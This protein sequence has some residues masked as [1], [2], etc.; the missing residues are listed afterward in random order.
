MARHHSIDYLE[1]PAKDLAAAKGFF[2]EL[3]GW[4]FSDF[5]PDYSAFKNAGVEGGFYRSELH[6]RQSE[7]SV[8][9][10]FYSVNLE[11]T[12]ADVKTCG[13]TISREI[14][15]FPGGRRFHFTDPNGNEYAVWSDA[16]V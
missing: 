13:G 9:V 10:V 15:D 4:Q 6:S 14:F 3:F 12:R 5:G 2:S 1:L 8:L 7:G 16:D 11:L